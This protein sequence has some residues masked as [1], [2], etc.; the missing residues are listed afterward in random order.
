MKRLHPSGPKLF[1]KNRFFTSLPNNVQFSKCIHIYTFFLRRAGVRI[2]CGMR[3]GAARDLN[4]SEAAVGIGD[5]DDLILTPWDRPIRRLYC[6]QLFGC[7]RSWGWK[8]QIKPYLYI[9]WFLD[10][11]VVDKTRFGDEFLSDEKS[12]NRVRQG[13][14]NDGQILFLMKIYY[15]IKIWKFIF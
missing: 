10:P 3:L 1:I 9:P 14:Q 15:R 13:F 4:L 5:T 7:W 2:E 6:S 12:T 11:R 8:I